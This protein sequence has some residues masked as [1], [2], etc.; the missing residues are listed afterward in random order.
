VGVRSMPLDG[1]PAVGAVG[2]LGGLYLLVSHSGVTLA[3]VLGRLVAQELGGVPSP[4]LEA[5]RPNRFESTP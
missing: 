1:K 2:S 4:E 3:P 5:Y